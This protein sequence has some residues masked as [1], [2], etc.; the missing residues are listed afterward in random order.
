MAT[1]AGKEAKAQRDMVA[2][3]KDMAAIDKTAADAKLV[4]ASLA[5]KNIDTQK[6]A[7]EAA[8]AALSAP[9][10]VRVADSLLNEAGFVSRT[11]EEEATAKAV[12]QEQMMQQQQMEQEQAAQQQA[13]QEQAAMAQQE[14]AQ[15]PQP[16]DPAQQ[17]QGQ[18]Q[19]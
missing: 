12:A 13:E 16:Q 10:A 19:F 18:P 1:I 2:A 9:G 11:D 4:L 7:I 8:L 6:A 15:Q 5:G 17:Q 3:Q 14:Q